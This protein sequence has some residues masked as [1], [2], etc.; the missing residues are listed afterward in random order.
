MR[1]RCP[2]GTASQDIRRVPPAP[3]AQGASQENRVRKAASPL[4]TLSDPMSAEGQ[5]ERNRPTLSSLASA[6]LPIYNGKSLIVGQI[7]FITDCQE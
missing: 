4:P 6:F 7:P 5:T 2:K 1:D 3:T